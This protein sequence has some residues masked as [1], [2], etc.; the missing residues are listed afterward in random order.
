[1]KYTASRRARA[2]GP[3]SCRSFT[4]GIERVTIEIKPGDRADSNAPDKANQQAALEWR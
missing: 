4:G 1:V 2:T 3:G